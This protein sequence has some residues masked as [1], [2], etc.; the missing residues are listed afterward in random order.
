M[1]YGDKRH[2]G[3]AVRCGRMITVSRF[4][5]YLRGIYERVSVQNGSGRTVHADIGYIEMG[6]KYDANKR[7]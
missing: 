2:V 4:V 6:F 1:Q 7:V 5:L 3:Y